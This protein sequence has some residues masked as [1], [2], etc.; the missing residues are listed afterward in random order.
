MTYFSPFVTISS[1]LTYHRKRKMAQKISLFLPFSSLTHLF[2]R[3]ALSVRLTFRAFSQ[4]ETASGSTVFYYLI[5]KVAIII[6]YSR[7]THR[8]YASVTI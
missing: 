7:I 6:F 1:L 4:Y 8:H 5:K 3:I 2:R